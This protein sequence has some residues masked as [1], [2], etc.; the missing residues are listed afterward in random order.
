MLL[1]YFQDALTLFSRNV[2]FILCAWVCGLD[3]YMGTTCVPRAYRGQKKVSDSLG[4]T[5]RLL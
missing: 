2:N 1:I 5:V 3:I 4:L